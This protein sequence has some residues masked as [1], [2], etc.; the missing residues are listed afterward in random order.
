MRELTLA[1]LADWCD[2]ALIQGVPSATVKSVSTD[3]RKVG[4]EDI[5]VALKGDR[6]DAHQFLGEVAERGVGAMLVS[7]LPVETERFSGGIIRVKDTLV[8]LQNLARQHRKTAVGLRVIGITGSNGKTSTKDF[9]SAVLMKGGGVNRTAGNLNNHIGLPLTVLSGKGRDRFGVWEMGMNHPGEIE[10]LAEI[11]KPDAAVITNI[12]TAHI[13]Y[14]GTREAIAAEK[15]SLAVS[16]PKGGYC[17]MP[18]TDEYYEFVKNRVTGEMI[19]VGIGQGDVRAEGLSA[20]PDGRMR[21]DLC[22][23]YG[24]SVPVALPVRGEHMVTNALLAAAVGLRE[25]ISRE[26]IAEALSD[27]VLTH[28]RL[29]EK[30]IRGISFLDDS[31]NANPDSMAAALATLQSAQTQG[32]RVAVLGFMGELGEHAETEHLRLGERV[33]ERG[34]DALVTVG[35]RAALIN[36]R[37]ATPA[38]NEHFATHAEA[39]DFLRDYLSE[40]DLVL[41]KGS[42]SAAMEQVIAGI[43]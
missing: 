21:F 35:E 26:A 9:L 43:Y 37:A 36:Q 4:Q 5:F 31:Y 8:A 19:P 16:V 7:A 33:S 23:V 32:R 22:S 15:S 25:G 6:F 12:G 13:E 11:A 1:Q 3:S 41:V 18:V 24:A 27:S 17:A 20:D 40:G 28:G 34:V 14:M 38:V 42:R 29:E 39:A 2:G 10:V 30:R